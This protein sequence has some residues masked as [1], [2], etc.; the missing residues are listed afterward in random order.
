M[1]KTKRCSINLN[2][3]QDTKKSK[4]KRTK[5]ISQ[6][7]V[8]SDFHQNN[9]LINQDQKPYS[10][11]Q[12]NPSFDT[13]RSHD[14]DILV[15]LTFNNLSSFGSKANTTDFD[16]FIESNRKINELSLNQNLTMKNLKIIQNCKPMYLSAHSITHEH[17][18]DRSQFG[19]DNFN[20]PNSKSSIK[21]TEIIPN[22]K[23][24]NLN[25]KDEEQFRCK[26]EYNRSTLTSKRSTQQCS[27]T[28]NEER[29]TLNVF[30]SR[31]FNPPNNLTSL[32][33]FANV[34]NAIGRYNVT[35]N[36]YSSN[37]MSDAS[38]VFQKM[39]LYLN[40]SKK[41]F[42]SS[43][44]LEKKIEAN[45][46]CGSKMKKNKILMDDS[47]FQKHTKHLEKHYRFDLLGSKNITQTSKNKKDVGL[48]VNGNN[49]IIFN[50]CQLFE[51]NRANKELKPQCI[52]CENLGCD[53]DK[54]YNDKY[55]A[56]TLKP[57]E[58]NTNMTFSN[59]FL[60][61]IPEANSFLK[62]FDANSRSNTSLEL[63][64]NIKD[65]EISPASKIH[66][67]EASSFETEEH[68][69]HLQEKSFDIVNNNQNKGN[70]KNKKNKKDK[71]K[72][73]KRNKKSKKNPTR[74]VIEEGSEK[75]KGPKF[76]SF[77]ICKK[78]KGDGLWLADLW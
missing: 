53:Q 70:R 36:E 20:F 10:D 50:F 17:Q 74:S 3:I 78:E 19:Y 2:N 27:H 67:V 28:A 58:I 46:T 25:D 66:N 40:G 15:N 8:A 71:Y 14:N 26:Y 60:Y 52:S 48:K 16:N 68:A 21:P 41:N 64:F 56:S 62:K 4:T 76:P 12:S 57:D 11:I 47:E 59:S 45:L 65:E 72:G 43:N 44:T 30:P 38:D 13:R 9:D 42:K 51:K 1:R 61:K 31:H 23:N 29:H 34:E 54:A 75:T 22:N 32:S 6:F 77:M 39:N 55:L 35:K 63:S 73:N 33:S 49:D 18:S 5:S 37:K 7:A 69:T 24:L